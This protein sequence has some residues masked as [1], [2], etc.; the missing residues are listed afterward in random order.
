M[1]RQIK[2]QSDLETVY[3]RVDRHGQYIYE[4]GL[5]DGSIIP[6]D[7]YIRTH[8]P[9]PPTATPSKRPPYWTYALTAFSSLASIFI[10]LIIFFHVI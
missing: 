7:E 8:T 4:V 3:W 2:S 10:L 6:Y 5:P 9:Y 1:E